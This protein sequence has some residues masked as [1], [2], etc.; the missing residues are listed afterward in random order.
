VTTNTAPQ[1][2]TTV[3]EVARIRILHLSDTH[4]SGDGTLHHGVVDTTAALA[5]VL[6]R[7]AEVGPLDLVVA[8]GDLSE[9]GS[10]SSY[11]T[12]RE[13]LEPWAGARGTA[14]VYAMGNHDLRKGFYSVLGDVSTVATVRGVRVVSLDSSVPGADFGRIGAEQLEWLHSVLGRP[15]EFG[16]IVV[17]HHPPVSAAT[18]L[19]AA[20]ELQEPQAL[21]DICAAGGVRLLLCGHYHHPMATRAHG[22]DVLVAPAVAN[23]S[24][25][26]AADGHEVARVGA[27]FAVVEIPLEQTAGA[28]RFIPVAAPCPQDG[29]VLFDLPP[30][31]LQELARVAGPP[32]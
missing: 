16:S 13:M 10:E 27:G 15:T 20:L 14:V 31:Q 1:Q 29:T 4:L 24:D 23:T 26:A 32:G 2:R 30:D 21:L 28:V 25:V 8:S 22:M 9:D 12:V 18:P 19:L 11:R 5:R 7:A 3:A 6:D 17:M